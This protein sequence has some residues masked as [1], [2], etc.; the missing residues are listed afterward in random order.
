VADDAARLWVDSMPDAYERWLAPTV[1]R[2]FAVD[3]ARRV[4]SLAPDRVLELA[5]GTGVLTR[6]LVTSLASAEVTATDLNVAMV[7]LGR[8]RAPGATWRSADAMDLP[9]DAGAFDVIACQFGVMF[10]P[11]KPAAFA[12]AR[13]VLTPDGTYLLNTWGTL[14]THDFQAALV[15]GLE[16]AFPEDPPTF[17]V[18]V[19]HGYADPDA[20]VADLHAAGLE[21]VAVDSV[22]LEGH[23]ASAAEVAAGYC[24]GTPLRAEIEA[25]GD[26]PT[27]TA[28]IAKE[29]EALLGTGAVTGTMTAHVIAATPA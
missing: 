23:A 12:E 21:C 7:E 11:S 29:M 24:T 25:R 15:A 13:R 2:P 22:T 5:A 18:S 3:L 1:F 17:M 4:A 28:V 20:V 9:F 26:L 8:Q 27:A 10:F 19:P 6:E 16:R 14:E